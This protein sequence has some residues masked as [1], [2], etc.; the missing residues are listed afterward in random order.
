MKIK[1]IE[2]QNFRSWNKLELDLEKPNGLVVITGL[3]G[4]GKSSA[5]YTL[6]YALYGELPDGSK[7]DDVVKQDKQQVEFV[8]TT[9]AYVNRLVNKDRV[10]EARKQYKMLEK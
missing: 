8:L 1:K 4:N 7:G 6:I 10:K 5:F 3:N 2:A 9:C